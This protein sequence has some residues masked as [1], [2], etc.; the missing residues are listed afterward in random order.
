MM[1]FI[2]NPI[3]SQLSSV[4]PLNSARLMEHSIDDLEVDE[5]LVFHHERYFAIDRILQTE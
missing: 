3:L 2:N 5:H 4:F 1:A